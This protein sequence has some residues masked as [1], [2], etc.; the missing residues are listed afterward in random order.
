[1]GGDIYRIKDLIETVKE[2]QKAAILSIS[3]WRTAAP[4]RWPVGR[5]RNLSSKRKRVG[6][7]WV[8][9]LVFSLL[10]FVIRAVFC[11]SL[12]NSRVYRSGAACGAKCTSSAKWWVAWPSFGFL[13]S[14][15]ADLFPGMADV[16]DCESLFPHLTKGRL[17]TETFTARH[18]PPS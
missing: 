12:Q 6:V 7:I 5:P 1:M 2:W 14:P 17:I 4:C 8:A 10:R 15:F 3:R 18:F 16:E 13:F 9:L 11:A